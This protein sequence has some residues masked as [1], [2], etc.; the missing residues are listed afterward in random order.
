MNAVM[1]RFFNENLLLKLISLAASLVLWAYVSAERFPNT[2][3][4]RNIRAE[5]KPVGTPPPDVIV[6]LKTET[7]PLLVTGPKSEV[8]SLNDN[9]I[10]AEVN[11]SSVKG[12][13][14]IVRCRAVHM[15]A[16]APNVTTSD[17]PTAVVE[18]VPRERKTLRITA[19]LEGDERLTSKYG[20]PRLS[21]DM[22]VVSGRRDD[23]QRVAKLVVAADVSKLGQFADLPVRPYDND[24]I[25]VRGLDVEPATTRVELS[26]ASADATRTLVVSVPFRG[27]TAFPYQ[28]TDITTE[29]PQI[30]VSGKPEVLVNLSH[31]ETE[32][33]DLS[34]LMSDV[35]KDIPLRLPAGVT[36]RSGRPQVRV[37]VKVRDTTRVSAPGT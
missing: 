25:E 21:P 30:V 31:I 6:N 5:V 2:T 1:A 24:G 18:V 9:D 22:A 36:L 15:P 8:D 13:T 35:T 19:R 29:P 17:R 4:S 12:S 32:E 37:T 14:S 26:L 20:A 27:Q 3:I 28:V 10:K 33:L 34:G 11:L 16:S 7:V 23:L